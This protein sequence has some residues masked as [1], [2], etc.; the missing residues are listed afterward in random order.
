MF[1][2]LIVTF[3]SIPQSSPVLSGT[4]KLLKNLMK[5]NFLKRNI[6]I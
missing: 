4:K 2:M 1:I 6:K 5:F 3:H